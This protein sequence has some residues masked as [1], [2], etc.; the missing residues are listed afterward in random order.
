MGP[1]LYCAGWL[2]RGPS[3]II[4]TNIIDARETVAAI[5]E[6]AMTG[7]LSF[8]SSSST[9]PSPPIFTRGDDRISALISSTSDINRNNNIS[10]ISP[11]TK[12]EVVVD[13]PQ[14]EKI[15]A[16]EV[17]AGIMQH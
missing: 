1:G 11:S 8:S 2:K 15:N 6:D 7:E 13:W 5:F 16:F 17:A 3:G 10:A 12:G 9:S 4:G 14:Y